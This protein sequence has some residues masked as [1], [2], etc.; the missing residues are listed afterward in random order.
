[1]KNKREIQAIERT[2]EILD[3]PKKWIKYQNALD[4]DGYSVFPPNNSAICWCLNGAIY[5]ALWEQDITNR[6]WKNSFDKINNAI[7]EAVNLPPP[8]YNEYEHVEFNDKDETTY[9]M[10]IDALQKAKEYLSQ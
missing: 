3:S 6:Q 7:C 8:S 4:K 10:V 2:L 1:M 9:E 5:K